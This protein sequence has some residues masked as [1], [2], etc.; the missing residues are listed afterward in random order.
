M[1]DE[2]ERSGTSPRNLP[3][4]CESREIE[5][6]T[7]SPNCH[8]GADAKRA[9]AI[10]VAART[11]PLERGSEGILPRKGPPSPAGA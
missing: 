9:S 1:S 6:V 10:E 2:L 11:Q 3:S 7:A 5:C 4:R 8:F